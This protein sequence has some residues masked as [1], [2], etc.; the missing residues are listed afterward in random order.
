MAGG[1]L[2][3][4][5]KMINMMYL[6]LTAL[7]ALNVSAE[8]LEAF[9][10]LRES[11]AE[12]AIEFATKNKDTKEGIVA[13]VDEEVQG[14]NDKNKDVKR[15]V[16]YVEKRTN[17]II[18]SITEDI[19]TLESIGI[20]EPDG[21]I[22]N[23]SE[24]ERN[25]QYWMGSGK[26]QENGGRGG[27]AAIELSRKL[28]GY[29]RWARQFAMDTLGIKK[30]DL[31]ITQVIADTCE[32]PG[33]ITEAEAQKADPK[34]K[35]HE[36]PWEYR[37]FHSK[38]IV[39]DLALLEKFKLD[40]Q[41]IHSDLLQI[42]KQR[43]GAVTFKIDSLILVE[44][45]FSRVVAAGMKFET[46]LFVAAT[47]ESAVPRFGGSG[48]IATTDGGFAAVMTM[49]APGSFA[50]G[51]NE[52]EVSYNA[53]A[54][55]TDAFGED[56]ELRLSSSYTVRKPE[57]VITSASVQ[58]LYYKCGNIINVDVPALGEFY[59]PVL[60]G[61]SAEILKSSSDKR[62]VTVV[63]SGRK[64]ILSV[65]SNTNGRVIKIDDVK[66]NVI[67]PPRPE[68]QLIVNG[69]EYNGTSPI[70]KK[71]RCVVR[72][73]P[74]SDFKA[75]LP[76]DARYAISQVK[77]LS[78]RSLGAPTTVG[79]YSGNGK[80]AEKGVNVNLGSKLK[81]DPPG[82]KIYFKLEKVYRINFKNQRVEE[83][84]GEIDLYIGA[85]IK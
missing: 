39:A 78:Q 36:H 13:K 29:A 63:P 71:S 10:S 75:A 62:K 60:K 25:Y 43:L 79:S 82:T 23:K 59:N 72:V 81:T 14:G 40:V 57:V 33:C 64:C 50:K 34:I 47:S 24:T 48:S 17:E 77:L 31:E 8:I 7:L 35:A 32:Y 2:S 56:K 41:N 84:F 21:K 9:E 5:Q 70:N 22:E 3:P 66:Y 12:S 28:N 46:K 76:R 52:K 51:Q 49:Q 4:R 73:K 6:V 55:I 80:N 19:D 15:W 74:D 53:T 42:L 37:T 65:S 30:E 45:P 85:I 44:A 16:Q 18:T 27:G 69:K 38:P 58:N 20:L 83:K 61:S 54:V 26:E 1:N 68:I 67:K 11:L